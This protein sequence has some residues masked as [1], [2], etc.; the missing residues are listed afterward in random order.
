MK[1]TATPMSSIYTLNSTLHIVYAFSC[2]PC[3]NIEFT[4]LG[5]DYVYY[6]CTW[7]RPKSGKKP[8]SRASVMFVCKGLL[9]KILFQ[10]YVNNYFII[11]RLESGNN[12]DHNKHGSNESH[13]DSISYTLSLHYLIYIYVYIT[14]GLHP[15]RQH[16][17]IIWYSYI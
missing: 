11:T 10:K 16:I 7:T 9:Q 15:M 1:G 3:K 17:I 12:Y 13:N 6:C 8:Y 5:S 14:E 2:E 4:C